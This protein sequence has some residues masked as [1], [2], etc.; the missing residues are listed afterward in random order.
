MLTRSGPGTHGVVYWISSQQHPPAAST[1]IMVGA[2]DPSTKLG[3]MLIQDY[4]RFCNPAPTEPG[5][6]YVPTPPHPPYGRKA[7]YDMHGKQYHV[8]SQAAFN[9]ACVNTCKIIQGQ[10]SLDNFNRLLLMYT[11]GKE[12]LKREMRE[13]QSQYRAKLNI[14]HDRAVGWAAEAEAAAGENGAAAG[15]GTGAKFIT[16][17]N[18]AA[19]NI[20]D[21]F[22]LQSNG[23]DYDTDDKD[24]EA[25]E[26]LIVDYT[27]DSS[28]DMKVSPACQAKSSSQKVAA[29]DLV[30]DFCW[31]SVGSSKDSPRDVCVI[32]NDSHSACLV[33]FELTPMGPLNCHKVEV[34]EDGWSL[35]YLCKI[36]EYKLD[37]AAI[38]RTPQT[39][40]IFIT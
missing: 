28:S 33:V 25:E 8:K 10:L 19:A 14:P 30:E 4:L 15:E 6:N 26:D 37:S 40:A 27:S 13:N 31:L 38:L 11:N 22:E 29:N 1:I 20:G 35:S 17:N 21:Q 2:Y 9:K 12:D 24:E 5:E 7:H 34:S 18:A 23:S 36:P 32:S 16:I 3:K 39:S